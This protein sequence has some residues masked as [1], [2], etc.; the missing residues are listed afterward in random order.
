MAD[1]EVRFQLI[2]DHLPYARKIARGISQGL[3]PCV[4]F[5]DLEGLARLGLVEAAERW[6]PS[7]GASFT[8]FAWYRIRGAIFDG[9]SRMTGI[10][11]T[12]RR[13]LARSRLEDEQV[14]VGTRAAASVSST[15]ALAEIF[16][17]TIQNV[18]LVKVASLVSA[19]SL[20]DG[21]EPAHDI[22]PDDEAAQSELIVLLRRSMADL[23]PE[24]SALIRLLYFEGLTCTEVARRRGVN[25]STVSRA[26]N[27]ILKQLRLEMVDEN[28][29]KKEAAR[30]S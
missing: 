17:S 6:D 25:K 19:A 5:D 24:D 20:E 21:G 1:Q 28:A 2:E 18:A 23:A 16:V 13:R 12:V 9:M 7:G 26:H 27:R 3:P 11:P 4:E 8:S 22:T 10:P 30:A 29:E 14:E 15:A